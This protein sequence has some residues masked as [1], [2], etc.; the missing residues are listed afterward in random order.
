MYDKNKKRIEVIKNIFVVVIILLLISSVYNTE[1]KKRKICNELKDFFNTGKETKY[2]SSDQEIWFKYKNKEVVNYYDIT[3]FINWYIDII[4]KCIEHKNRKIGYNQFNILKK[5]RKP[6]EGITIRGMDTEYF[7]YIIDYINEEDIVLYN[8]GGLNEKLYSIF[9]D[10]F[11]YNNERWYIK[12]DEEKN[13]EIGYNMYIKYIPS[14]RKDNGIKIIEDI[15]IE[16]YNSYGYLDFNIRYGNKDGKINDKEFG[17]VKVLNPNEMI[18]NIDDFTPLFFSNFNNAE[19]IIRSHDADIEANNLLEWEKEYNKSKLTSS[20]DIIVKTTY[21]NIDLFSERFKNNHPVI[22]TREMKDGTCK[23]FFRADI[24]YYD[25]NK[26]ITGYVERELPYQEI[27]SDENLK[28]YLEDTAQIDKD[29]E[30][31]SGSKNPTSEYVFTELY[32]RSHE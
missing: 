8:T 17:F 9:N 16:K 1:I 20:S 12:G 31:L 28:M 29:I 27:D 26:Y 24:I 18:I 30:F 15:K 23:S 7:D 10:D 4:N 2:L 6:Y 21:S 22:G 25:G 14:K 32:W 5:I 3:D 11:I 13:I 19:L